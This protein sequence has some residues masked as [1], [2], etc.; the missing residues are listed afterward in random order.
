MSASIIEK[1]SIGKDIVPLQRAGDE[2]DMA[3]A[4]LYLAS[5]AG[6][7][8]NG[9]IIITDGGRLTTVPSTF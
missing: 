1:G 3:G 7:Y 2:K 9:T 6:A 4:I 5:R 8:C